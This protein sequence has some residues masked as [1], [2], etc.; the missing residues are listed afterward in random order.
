[1]IKEVKLIQN[2]TYLNFF[3]KSNPILHN[4]LD[5]NEVSEW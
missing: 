1:M 5:L 3:I 4:N 2:V